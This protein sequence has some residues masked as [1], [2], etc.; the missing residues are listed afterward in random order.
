MDLTV[1]LV[2][3]DAHGDYNSAASSPT[4]RLHGQHNTY[5]TLIH[6]PYSYLARLGS[7]DLKNPEQKINPVHLLH[8]GGRE[9]DP[10]ERK[11]MEIDK[12]NLFT[13]AQMNAAKEQGKL[14]EAFAE[15]YYSSM[16]GVDAVLVSIDFDVL[17]PEPWSPKPGKLSVYLPVSNG[18]FPEELTSMLEIIGGGK[19]PVAGL[20]T[21]ELKPEGNSK[22]SFELGVD[23]M[24][25]FFRSFEQGKTYR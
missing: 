16:K 14:Y 3:F 25:K 21:S 7:I 24:K 6:N 20:F 22:R 15:K 18:L 2:S 4:N 9:F 12:V 5:A 23:I 10:W 13:M 19:I 17:D 1:G 11:L 8:V